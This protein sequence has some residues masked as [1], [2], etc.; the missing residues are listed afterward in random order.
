MG[1]PYIIVPINS[2]IYLVYFTRIQEYFFTWAFYFDS[3]KPTVNKE[4]IICSG[5]GSSGRRH[6]II[7]TKA[8][9]LLIRP[10]GTNFNEMSIELHTFAFKKIRL[11]MPSGKWWPFFSRP[12]CVN[13]M[14]W[15]KMIKGNTFSNIIAFSWKQIVNKMYLSL[16]F[17][18]ILIMNTYPKSSSTSDWRKRDDRLV[19][20][21]H[22]Y[23]NTTS[24]EGGIQFSSRT[25]TTSV[26]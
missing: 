23:V 10:L 16:I 20:R 22:R 21:N 19:L 4:T 2:S 7:W 9:I 15:N 14:I 18:F 26:P 17:T 6:D 3:L 8:G 5:S 25:K 13:G 11:K 1:W 24:P 12:Q